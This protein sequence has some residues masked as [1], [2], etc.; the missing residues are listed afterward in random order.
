MDPGG[1][2]C[3]FLEEVGGGDGAAPTAADVGQ[4]GEGG[5]EVVG[6]VIVEGHVPH[7]FALGFGA[8]HDLCEHFVIVGE[9]TDVDVAEGNDDGSGEGGGVDDVGDTETA[10]V[11]NGVDEDEAAFGVGVENFNGFAAEGGDDVAGADGAAAAH[12]FDGGDDGGDGD[13]GLELG[14]GLHGTDDGR[15]AGHVVLHFLHAVGGL[16]GDAAGVEGDAFADEAEVILRGCRRGVAE[17]D[18]GRRFGRAS[19]DTEERAHAELLHA[20]FI[21]DF[22]IE[23]ELDGHFLGASGEGEGREEVAGFVDQIASEVLGFGDGFAVGHGGGEIFR[24]DEVEGGEV[25]RLAFR[26]VNIHFEIAEDG[27]FD[28]SGGEGGFGVGMVKEERDGGDAFGFKGADGGTGNPAEDCGGERGRGA[29]S[30]GDEALGGEA[31]GAVE[32]G[33][34]EDFAFGFAGGFEFGEPAGGGL[35]GGF[36]R[37][38]GGAAFGFE[39][40]EEERVG[41]DGGGGGG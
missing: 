39:V 6:V 9:G 10:S 23:A 11:F 25:G 18:H 21:E 31:D 20:V 35:I 3:P 2:A 13:A 1:A 38:D 27:A 16:D 5:F 37:G 8:G 19:G 33:E 26:L 30:E 4:V 32:D 41:F 12:V 7:V 40:E 29:G 22:A 34:V 14:E 36:E 15:A 17:D 24:G 28:G